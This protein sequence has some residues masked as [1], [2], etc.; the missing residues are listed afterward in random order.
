MLG[1][2]LPSPPL[3]L[4]SSPLSCP[5]PLFPSLPCLPLPPPPSSPPPVPPP[6]S[7]SGLD[8][9]DMGEQSD[10]AELPVDLDIEVE[11]MALDENELEQLR[12][13]TR[14]VFVCD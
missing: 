1:F 7:H 4:L 14:C 2:S 12:Q 10:T 5:V 9:D 6:P 3:P 8:D 13:D 11:A